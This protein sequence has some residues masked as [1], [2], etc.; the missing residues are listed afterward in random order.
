MRTLMPLF[1]LPVSLSPRGLAERH[2]REANEKFVDALNNLFTKH[3]NLS[4]IDHVWSHGPHVTLMSPFN[5]EII[6]GWT[7]IRAQ[8][9]KELQAGL[10]GRVSVSALSVQVLGDDAAFVTGIVTSDKLRNKKGEPIKLGLRTTSV[11]AKEG[12]DWV[13]VHHHTDLGEDIRAKVPEM[14]CGPLGCPKTNKKPVV[15]PTPAN[16]T[17]ACPPAKKA[18]KSHKKNQVPLDATNCT[19]YTDHLGRTYSFTTH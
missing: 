17:A 5:N 2:V 3:G 9:E 10:R 12:G 15:S 1:S 8:Y 19:C 6:T 11:F 13:L 4:T 7:N 14:Q 18:H 16:S